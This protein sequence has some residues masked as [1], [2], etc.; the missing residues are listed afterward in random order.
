M[1]WFS[2]DV[3]GHIVYTFSTLSLEPS[4]KREDNEVLDVG[5]KRERTVSGKTH[6][7]TENPIHIVSTVGLELGVPEVEG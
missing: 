7:G 6:A 4:E 5:G 1:L 2:C 3:R